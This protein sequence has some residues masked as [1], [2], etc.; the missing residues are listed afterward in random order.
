MATV[1]RDELM[2]YCRVDGDE[3]GDLVEE[4]AESAEAY[5]QDAG[6]TYTTATAPVY[7]QAVK[8]LTL[9]YLDNPG[10]APVPQGLQ[11][12]IN[13]LKFTPAAGS[14]GNE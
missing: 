6:C 10:G 3:I 5:L 1:E 4:L 2:L 14:A 13:K 9:H 11:S 8:A 7:R 12:L